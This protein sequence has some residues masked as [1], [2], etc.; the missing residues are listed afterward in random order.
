MN[1]TLYIMDIDGTIADP[2]DFFIKNPI[3]KNCK[4]GNKKYDLWLKK[5]HTRKNLMKFKPIKG[6]KDLCDKLSHL[7]PSFDRDWH[8][9]LIYLTSR[10]ESLRKITEDWLRKNKFPLNSNLYMRPKNDKSP[11]FLFK[12]NIIKTMIYECNYVD[13]AYTNVIIFDDDTKG[14]LEKICKKNS[15]TFF[16]AKST[17]F[18]P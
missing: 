4:R 8:T 14:K 11:Y 16:K 1:K 6:M 10:E 18:V 5:T 12:E 3:P 2:G 13:S 17:G 9:N 7:E 15:W